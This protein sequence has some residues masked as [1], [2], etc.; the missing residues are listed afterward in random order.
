MLIAAILCFAPVQDQVE[1]PEYKGWK[2]FKPGSSVTFK[3]SRE[4]SPQGGEQKVTLKSI[5]DNEAV[6]A[7]EFTMAGKGGGKALERNVP[8][9]VTPAEAPERKEGPEEEIEVSGKM[10]KCRTMSF[11]KKLESGKTIKMK[12][13]AN[14]DVPGGVAKVETS[15]E[16]T[17][18]VSMVATQWEKK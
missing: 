1:N 9:K 16:G 17:G 10:L 8:A 14:L 3:F 6:V 5:D 18:Q 4:R 13:W 11:E 12:L 7:T 15:L 2:P